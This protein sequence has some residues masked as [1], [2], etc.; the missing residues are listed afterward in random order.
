MKK[1]EEQYDRFVELL[2]TPLPTLDNP[3]GL[4]DSIWRAIDARQN[5]RISGLHRRRWLWLFRLSGM[6]A[7]FLFAAWIGS[8]IRLSGY[9]GFRVSDCPVVPSRE[10]V[11]AADTPIEKNGCLQVAWKGREQ[12]RRNMLDACRSSVETYNKRR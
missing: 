6:A 3:D 1:D 10:C 7:A 9:E 2:R 11:V 12:E 4:A 8:G 5:D